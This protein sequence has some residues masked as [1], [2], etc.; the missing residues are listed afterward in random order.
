MALARLLHL[1]LWLLRLRF[2]WSS[3][4]CTRT[5]RSLLQITRCGDRAGFTL[6]RRTWTD[7]CPEPR[8]QSPGDRGRQGTIVEDHLNIGMWTKEAMELQTWA[9]TCH[10]WLCTCLDRRHY[11]IWTILVAPGERD[12]CS[13]FIWYNHFSFAPGKCQIFHLTYLEFFAFF[14]ISF[15]RCSPRQFVTLWAERWLPA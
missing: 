11:T 7:A 9:T 12:M 4:H 2:V 13:L 10:S 8:G 1:Y 6:F 15:I 5:E 3:N 14:K